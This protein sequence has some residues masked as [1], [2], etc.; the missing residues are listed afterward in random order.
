GFLGR[1]SSR[2]MGNSCLAISSAEQ[3]TFKWTID[4]VSSL[5]NKGEGWTLS[6]LFMIL[7]LDWYLMLNLRDR[8]SGDEN[9]YVSLRLELPYGP[10]QPVITLHPILKHNFE[11]RSIS[12]RVACMIPLEILKKQSSGFFAG[13]TCVFG[14]KFI[15]VV[16]AK[17]NLLSETLFVQKMNT[18]N[19]AKTYTWNIQ[20]F[21]ALKNP[22]Q[23]PDFEIGG[24]NW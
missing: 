12:A 2:A 20:D 10:K 9:D 23:S 19:E 5:L 17:A 18:F 7:G 8:K 22:G 11:T 14:V 15:K 21:F 1:G 6:G 4:G 16:I 13:D 3:T 24:Y